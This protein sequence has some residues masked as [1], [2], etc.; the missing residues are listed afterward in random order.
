MGNN[1]KEKQE[2]KTIAY[3][4]L[5]NYFGGDKFK[6]EIV[7]GASIEIAIRVYQNDDEVKFENGV[8]LSVEGRYL[9]NCFDVSIDRDNVFKIEKNLYV[10]NMF[11]LIHN[12]DR[13]EADVIGYSLDVLVGQ[14]KDSMPDIPKEFENLPVSESRKVTEEEFRTFILD[15]IDDFDISDNKKAQCPS[16]SFI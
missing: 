14:V 10:D 5:F 1:R 2:L 16:V 4:Y 13:I 8:E 12:F 7:M 3:S 11:R 15:H 9:F 6:G